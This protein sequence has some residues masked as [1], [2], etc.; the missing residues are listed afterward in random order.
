MINRL[1]MI[2]VLLAQASCIAWASDTRFPNFTGEH[3]GHGKSVWQ[4]NCST[5]HA[6]GVAD[7]PNPVY[8]DEWSFRLAKGKPVLYEHA[9]NGFFGID[10]AYMPPRG[11]NENLSNADVKAAVDYMARLAEFYIQ[12]HEVTQDDK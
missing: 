7:A 10:D 3:L 9:I 2:G 8:P 5:C 4:D 11:G 12:Q 1:F 6:Y